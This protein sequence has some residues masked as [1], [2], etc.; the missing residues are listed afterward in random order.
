MESAAVRVVSCAPSAHGRRRAKASAPHCIDAADSADLLYRTGGRMI[1]PFFR[2]RGA[3]LWLLFPVL[4]HG[5]PPAAAAQGTVTGRVTLLEAQGARSDDLANA[6]IYL[7][8]QGSSPA[9]HVTERI[10]MAGREFQ[11]TVRVVPA[12]SRVEFPNEDPFRH[13]VFSNAGPGQFDLGLYGRG[14]S[15]GAVF[16]RPGVYPIFCNIHARMVAFVVAVPSS[17]LAQASAD[18]RF[19]IPGVP[20]GR[21]TIRAWHDRGGVHER[22]V[23]IPAAGSSDLIIQLDARAHV[24]VQHRNKFGQ[25]YRATS[26]DRY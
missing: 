7:D 5:L 22:E 15:R 17:L 8:A 24:P 12:G 3:L 2:S 21:Y 16:A 11:P 9:R 25:E 20:A 26:R 1:H 10:V 14:T 23:V 6:V 13:N 4:I 19:T 18:G